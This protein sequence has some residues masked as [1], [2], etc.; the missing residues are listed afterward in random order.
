MF[1]LTGRRALI[2]GGSRGIGAAC[3]TVF[4]AAGAE[5]AF[6][7]RERSDRADAL[8]AELADAGRSAHAI[9]ADLGSRE[10][11]EHLVGDAVAQLGGLDILVHNAGIWTGGVI[12]SMSDEIW[13][14]T[15][16]VNL[17]SAFYL[18]RAAVGHLR[19]RSHGRI[20]YITSTAAQRGEAEHS[21]YAASK[22]ALQSLT[23][24]LAVE[25][26]PDRITVNALAPGWV[27]TDMVSDT[28][29]VEEIAE[30]EK[31]IPRG[32]MAHPED[33]ARPVAFLASDGAVHITG[34]IL[35]VNGGA[36]LCG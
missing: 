6:S 28:L 1:D 23:K 30:V 13:R 5:V 22:G 11:C 17:D 9:R 34:E 3:V 29:S 8:V 7:W 10:G 21:H 4:S 31:I 19:E 14:E 12:E 26:A 25:L 32:C 2:T 18:T 36:V 15:M 24:S 20:I 33:I 35:N 16:Q 27:L